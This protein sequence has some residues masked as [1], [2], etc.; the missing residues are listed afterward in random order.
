M[1]KLLVIGYVWPEPKSSAAGT[2][3]MQLLDFFYREGYTISFATTA[4]ET[5]NRSDLESKGIKI[6][7]IRLN[8]PAFDDFIMD[9]MPDAVLF[10]RYMTEEQFGW[11]ID[12]IC[13]EAIK[14]LDTEDLHF[15]RDLRHKTFKNKEES[16]RLF[17]DSELAKREIGAI[18]R[19][20]ISLIIS[21]KE[22][23]IL[24]KKFQVPSFILHYLPFLLEPISEKDI[25]KLPSFEGRKDLI[26][27][28][29]FLHEPNWNAVLEL[30]EKIWPQ[31]K[32]K[33]PG[34]KMQIY[35]AYASQKV[36]KLHNEKDR[37]LINGWTNDSGLVMKTARLCVAPINF[38]AG[39]KGKLV[40]AMQNGTP[41]ITTPLGAEAI[42]GE[43]SW[44]GYITSNSEEFVSKTLE[45]YTDEM[46]W[47]EKQRYGFEIINERFD[48][49][50]HEKL[51]H[52][53]I[54]ELEFDLLDHR[55][56]NFT[57]N[58]MKFHLNRSSYYLSRYIEEKNKK[59]TACQ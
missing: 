56:R 22:M 13:P 58:M 25:E 30:K 26:W 6:K 36:Y 32:G 10:D 55:S 1:K 15:L 17:M 57:G 9:L 29:N 46:L 41:S 37:F 27:I 49:Q 35:G 24:K 8:D 54:Y 43:L 51:F 33:L 53:R 45:L 59:R 40:E 31:L 11:R 50:Q 38:G 19:C 4:K 12:N 47:N 21:E 18:Y 20:D 5:S 2:R 23:E 48:K 44:P 16:E 28:G 42:N 34:A 52:E 3:M 39:L 14:I 7:K